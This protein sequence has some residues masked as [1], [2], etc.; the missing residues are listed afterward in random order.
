MSSLMNVYKRDP[1]HKNGQS[2]S[3]EFL[4]QYQNE[5]LYLH[6]EYF[7]TYLLKHER[8]FTALMYIYNVH[9]W[10]NALKSMKTWCIGPPQ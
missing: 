10:I 5:V 8:M 2:R 3:Y 6:K 1:K 9:K 4:F 7:S